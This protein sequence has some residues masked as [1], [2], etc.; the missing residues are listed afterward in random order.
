MGK[1]ITIIDIEGLKK[2]SEN[3][4]DAAAA[5]E[6]YL[7]KATDAQRPGDLTALRLMVIR[8]LRGSRLELAFL[9]QRILVLK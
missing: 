3:L 2:A 6:E 5:A 9:R 7:E 4:E 8:C 1:L